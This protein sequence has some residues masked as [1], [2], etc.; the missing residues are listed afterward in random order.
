MQ[1][2]IEELTKQ[3]SD[4]DTKINTLSEKEGWTDRVDFLQVEYDLLLEDIS[5]FRK[6]IDNGNG[7]MLSLRAYCVKGNLNMT[8]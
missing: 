7:D 2:T 6:D 3:A 1:K 5:N 8:S 4:L